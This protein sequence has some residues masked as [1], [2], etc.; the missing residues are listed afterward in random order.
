M[1]VDIRHSHTLLTRFPF[2][3]ELSLYLCPKSFNNICVFMSGFFVLSHW[4]VCLFFMSC[5]INADLYYVEK[6][7]EPKINLPTSL[8]HRKSKRIP[9]KHLLVFN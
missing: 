9:E 7:E 1:P 6:A 2:L 3:P 4:S 5:L 8:D